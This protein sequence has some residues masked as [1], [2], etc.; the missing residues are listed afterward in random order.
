MYT[1]QYWYFKQKMILVFCLFILVWTVPTMAQD[2]GVKRYSKANQHA[3]IVGIN[4]YRTIT[5]LEGTINDALLLRDVL[6]RMNVQ[7]PEHRVLL[8]EQATR[9]NFLKAWEDML[10][11]AKP[12][13]TLILTFSGHGAQKRDQAPLDEPDQ[14]DETLLFHEFTQNTSTWKGFITDDELHGLFKQA[15]AYNIVSLIDACHSSGMVRSMDKPTG[16]FRSAGYWNIQPKMPSP[17]PTHPENQQPLPH[18]TLITAV[19]HD[20]LKVPETILDNKPHG[21]LSWFFAQALT[22]EADGN[23]NGRLERRELEQFLHETVGDHMN[24]LQTP[25]LVPRGDSQ[26]VLTLS[27]QPTVQIQ[28]F[29]PKGENGENIAIVV[30]NAPLPR[31]I[32]PVKKVDAFQSFDLRFVVKNRQTEVFNNTGD[33]VATLPTNAINLWQRVIDKERLLKKLETQFDMRLTSLKISLRDGNKT[34]KKGEVRHFL[35][36]QSNPTSHLKAL[37][38]FNLAGNGELEFLYPLSEYRDPLTVSRFPYELPPL[39]VTAPF[40]GDDLVAILCQKPAIRLHQFL[41][42][43]NEKSKLPEPEQFLRHLRNNTCQVGQH[44]FFSSE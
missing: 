23:Q 25:K 39:K 1:R 32:K 6:R 38:V 4:Q 37:T 7:V 35:L 3:L 41:A 2:R 8:N 22:G 24:N 19:A 31:G 26:P 17:L 42:K 5:D 28:S 36:E 12:G 44:A 34:Y 10:K 16:R 33:K 14:R 20:S 29:S 15:S 30:E 21:A 11:R 40:G 9:D 27:Q 13:D 43:H 18:V